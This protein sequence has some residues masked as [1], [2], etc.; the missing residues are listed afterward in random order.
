MVRAMLNEGVRQFVDLR[1]PGEGDTYDERVRVQYAEMM[2]QQHGS[3]SLFMDRTQSGL[4]LMPA[5]PDAPEFIKMP[6]P[7]LEEHMYLAFHPTQARPLGGGCARGA[8]CTHAR[9]AAQPRMQ[10]VVPSASTGRGACA[11]PAMLP[12]RTVQV[13]LPGALRRG[14][15]RAV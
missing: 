10:G 1:A 11:Q 7:K 5:R 4:D 8:D 13:R 9:A 6:I 15:R 2:M 12:S 14:A 3:E